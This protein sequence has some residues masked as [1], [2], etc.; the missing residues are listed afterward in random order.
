MIETENILYEAKPGPWGRIEYFFTFLDPPANYFSDRILREETEWAFIDQD[1]H[2][3]KTLLESWGVVPHKDAMFI[4]APNGCLLRPGNDFVREMPPALLQELYPRLL[5]ADRGFG[6]FNDFVIEGGSYREISE[7]MGIPE[8]VIH[9]VE[10][11][12]IT[13]GKKKIFLDTPLALGMLRTESQKR[14]FLQSL[15]RTRAL[16]GRLRVDADTPLRDVARWWSAGA[17]RSRALPL[18]ETALR[19]NGISTIDLLH[20]LPPVPRRL[21]YTFSTE[22]DALNGLAPDCYWAAM[23]FFSEVASNRYLDEDLPRH[24]YFTEDWFEPVSN[25]NQ[26]GDISVLHSPKEGKFVHAWVHIADN[27][28]YTK[29]G[30]GRFFPYLLMQKEDMLSR[31]LYSGDLRIQGYRSRTLGLS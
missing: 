6:H 9:F 22:K 2:Q 7:G 21:L 4:K 8:E 31:Y 25:P 18:L 10:S 15:A 24:Y 26:F 19:A 20:L 27:I 17:N 28:V 13:F 3:V 12:C 5:A 1:V 11:R 14:V 23:N 30:S 29:N 16:V